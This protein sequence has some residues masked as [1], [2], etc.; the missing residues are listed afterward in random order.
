MVQYRV[1]HVGVDQVYA[2]MRSRTQQVQ[3]MIS[4]LERTSEATVAEWE[5]D[6]QQ[7]YWAAKSE[8][9]SAASNMAALADRMALNLNGIN[10]NYQNADRG[11][12]GTFH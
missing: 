6:A 10:T 3:A 11:A 5:G 2:D 12:A 1:N 8:W 9:N 7:A 4:D